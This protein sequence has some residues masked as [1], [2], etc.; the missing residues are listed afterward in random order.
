MR[1]HD[2]FLISSLFMSALLICLAWPGSRTVVYGAARQQHLVSV[3]AKNLTKTP[4]RGPQ[5]PDSTSRSKETDEP[6]VAEESSAEPDAAHKPSVTRHTIIINGQSLNYTA[7][8][9]YLELKGKSGQPEAELFF[10]AYERNDQKDKKDKDRWPITFAFNGGPGAA[11]VFL[12]LGALGPR[13]IF[14]KDEGK[15]VAPPYRLLDNEY[16]WLAFT[17]LVFIDPMGTG[18]SRLP[19]S[20]GFRPE[21][22]PDSN[23]ASAKA[24]HTVKEPKPA[25]AQSEPNSQPISLGGE[26]EEARRFYNLKEDIRLAADFIRLYITRYR[27]WSSPKFIVGESY[28]ATRAAALAGFL[29]DKENLN[30]NGLVL[31]S[32]ALDFQTIIFSQGN[33]LPYC[34]FLPSY[35]AAAWYHRKLAPELQSVELSKLLK[36]TANWAMSEY[37]LALLKGDLLSTP[38]RHQIVEKLARYTALSPDYIS[39]HNLRL[40]PPQFSRELLRSER[41][42]IGLLDSRISG[43]DPDPSQEH[44]EY[45]PSL[46]MVSGPFG[47]A[48]SDYVRTELKYINDLRYEVLNEEVNRSWDW[49]LGQ[50]EGQGFTNVSA[51]LREAIS[52]NSALKVFVAAG[53]Y[54]LTTP[55]SATDYTINHLGLDPNLRDNIEIAYYEVGHQIY[56]HLP[57]LKK[58]TNDAAAFIK[59]ALAENLA[60]E[61]P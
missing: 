32:P 16:S 11:S 36:E 27:R 56:V 50:E 55:Y 53:Y 13:R 17:D 1:K 24:S 42:L 44:D 35:T 60:E 14:L 43:P 40:S 39:S 4:S 33:D 9:G 3:A 38:E 19:S 54:D 52:K 41:R 10:V 7:T 29:Q 6:V 48:M 59:S 2:I 5:Q 12:H 34:L 28:G 47:A 46:F 30:L 61:K 22:K 26:E 57:S 37:S 8:A 45:D 21:S 23:P 31:I 58:L 20:G 18:Y 25:S 51:T 49:G 15:N